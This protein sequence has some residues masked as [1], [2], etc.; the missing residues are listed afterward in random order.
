MAD[1][2]IGAVHLGMREDHPQPRKGR[3]QLLKPAATSE[4][5]EN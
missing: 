5:P 3:R 2:G 4:A 1:L